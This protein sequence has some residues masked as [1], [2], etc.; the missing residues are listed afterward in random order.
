MNIIKSMNLNSLLLFY[1]ISHNEN[2]KGTTTNHVKRLDGFLNS[3]SN[4]SINNNHYNIHGKKSNNRHDMGN[5]SVNNNSGEDY[6][7]KIGIYGWR[8]RCLYLLI[9]ILMFMMIINFVLTLWV[10]K[11]MDFNLVIIFVSQNKEHNILF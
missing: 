11:V 7:V 8:K 1:R 6:G 4:K 3:Q 5:I 10:L 2:P 9:L